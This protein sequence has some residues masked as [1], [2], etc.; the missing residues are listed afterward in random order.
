MRI[1]FKL[2]LL[3]F[4]AF[5]SK[6]AKSTHNRAGEI[7]YTHIEGFE[8][9]IRII[10]CTKESSPADRPYLKIRWGDEGPNVTEADL[11]SLPR[12]LEDPSVGFDTKRNEY[13]GRHVYSGTGT[14]RITVEDPNRNAN[15]L[16][17][18]NGDPGT[19]QIDKTSV[20]VMTIFCIESVL[21]ITA[22][23]N[24]HNNSVR[25]LNPPKEQACVFQ[26]WIHNPAAYDPDGD[27]LVYSLVPCRGS[28]CLPLETWET[29][30]DYTDD[31][32]DVFSIDAQTGDVT[33][34]YPLVAGEYNIAILIEEFRDGQFVGSV[35]RDMQITVLN[36]N[37][38]PPVIQSI[39]DQC[40]TAGTAITDIQ[41]LA[42]DP[43]GNQISYAIYGGPLTEVENEGTWNTVTHTFTWTPECEEIRLQPY[44]ITFEATDNASVPLTDIETVNITVVA[45]PVQNPEANA[46]GNQINLSWDV[47]PCYNIFSPSEADDVTY[48]VYRRSGE[49]GFEPHACELGVPGYTGYVLIG[50]AQGLNNN[51]YVDTDLSYGG[52]YCYMIATCWPDGAI[53]Y[54]SEEFC[55][56]I[57]KD[58]PVLTKVSVVTTD[59]IA[60][61]DS[62]QWSKPSE[63][64]TLVFLPPYQYKLYHGAGFNTPNQLIFTSNPFNSLGSGD[65]TF[66]HT[67]INTQSSGNNYSVEFI[68]GTNIATSSPASSVFLQLTPL[69]KSVELQ[70]IVDVPWTNYEYWIYRKGPNDLDFILIDT[71]YNNIYLDTALINNELY[72]YKVLAMG[73]YYANDVPNPLYNWSQQSCT[74]PYDMTPPCPPELSVEHYCSEEYDELIWNNP[75]EFCADDVQQYNIYYAPIEGQ[76]LQLLATIDGAGNTVY[77]YE[78]G[79]FPLSIAGCFA[80]TALD[81]LSLWPDGE[82]HQNESAFSDT[83]CVDNCPIYFLPN[84]FSPNNDGSNDLFVPFE[85]RYIENVD[86]KVFNRW[87]NLVFETTDPGLKWNG[88]PKGGTDICSDGVYFYVI[89]V[90][91][92]RLSGIVKENF[93]GTIQLVGGKTPPNPN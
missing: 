18:N 69:D 53:S 26:P 51:S 12:V 71:A 36:C 31:P 29:P 48:K 72:C 52:A 2:L 50:E 27:E 85:Y 93:S 49:Y 9:E 16:N 37:N 77:L 1:V 19:P 43:N 32:S 87:G 25:L 14:F 6:E 82:Y 20:S 78:G 23:T 59:L 15:V 22:G 74:T 92:I 7:I 88:V 41:V 56:T 62:I 44:T 90:N 47:H 80:V 54:A 73:S 66:V 21:V 24:G 63:I 30:T 34:L 75:N 76:P 79:S 86:F 35:L 70:M 64:D 17:I 38:N 91:T 39:P 5:L 42:I 83:I 57:I 3:L 84:I 46:E 65:T 13:V 40:V 61:I 81:S 10:T 55:D 28:G 58:V 4:F 67:N 33:W 60:G 68:S 45:P 89:E 11:D 8:Y